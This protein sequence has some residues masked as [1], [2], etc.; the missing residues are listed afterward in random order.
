MNSINRLWAKFWSGSGQGPSQIWSYQVTVC[1][2]FLRFPDFL[3]PLDN[4]EEGRSGSSRTCSYLL[5]FH[6]GTLSLVFSAGAPTFE[7]HTPKATFADALCTDACLV[8][9][10]NQRWP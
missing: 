10:V 7:L 3:V 5:D 2:C 8:H 9:N 6:K 4:G 1:Y